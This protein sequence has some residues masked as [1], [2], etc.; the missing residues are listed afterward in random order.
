[1]R[2]GPS[3]SM[4]AETIKNKCCSFTRDM[5]C[6]GDNVGGAKISMSG[7]WGT[8]SPERLTTWESHGILV[9]SSWHIKTVKPSQSLKTAMTFGLKI[10]RSFT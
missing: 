6:L 3:L 9:T 10:K 7:M 4:V 8:M 2:R 5:I 1:M